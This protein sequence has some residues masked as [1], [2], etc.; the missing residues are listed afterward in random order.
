MMTTRD[1]LFYFLYLHRT[2]LTVFGISLVL[3]VW[4]LVERNPYNLGLSNLIAIYAL[5]VLGL[6]L[7][8][9]YTG[10]ISLGH[11]AFFAIGAYGS[12]IGTTTFGLPVWPVMVAVALA[13]ALVALAVGLPALK[14]SGHYLAMATLGFNIV[15]YTILVQWDVVTGGP[16]G[17][18]GIPYLAIGPLVFDNEVRFHYLVW[19]F[20]MLALLLCLN[21]VRSGVGRGL[22]ALAE[23]ETAAAALG[24]NIRRAKIKVFVLSAVLAALA[25]SLF[26]HCYA[27]VSPDSFGIFVSVDFVI[28]VVV[29]GMSSIWGTL[30]GTALIT[31]LPEWIES[32]ESFKD[33]L[34]GL[35][36]VL[37]LL[38]LPQGLVT[39]IVDAIRTRIAL[40]RHHA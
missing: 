20:A 39:G 1:K 38:F 32:L 15:V 33:I 5:V 31:L 24:V 28:M 12:A 13:T 22:A 7:F 34:H 10:Q 17:F 29:G 4:P 8:I 9:G 37:I 27:F 14:L 11:A 6:N 40:G 19:T 30:F 35:I 2:G 16:S 25:G 21:L 36:L 3:L 18:A 26:A 23:D